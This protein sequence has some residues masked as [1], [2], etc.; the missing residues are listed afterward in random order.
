M[1]VCPLS[2]EKAHQL[3]GGASMEEEAYTRAWAHSMV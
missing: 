1:R 3:G 2:E